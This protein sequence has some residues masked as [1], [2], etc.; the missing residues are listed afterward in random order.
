[1][2]AV[3]CAPAE[4]KLAEIARTYKQSA[5]FVGGVHKNLR[6]LACLSVFVGYIVNIYI[7]AYILH[8]LYARR[9]NIYLSEIR[10][11][12]FYKLNGVVI[13]HICCAKAGHGYANN[14]FFG[15]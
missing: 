10:T 3:V 9:L 11:E 8:M 7:V 4:C 2:V 15:E 12:A 1:M 14:I 6:S 5:L 13:C